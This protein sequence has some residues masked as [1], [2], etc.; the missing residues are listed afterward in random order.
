MSLTAL[1]QALKNATT[2]N[3]VSHAV[4]IYE[5]YALHRIAGRDF[6]Y[7]GF[8]LPHATFRWAGFDEN[9]HCP[10]VLF[11]FFRRDGDC[12][13]CP[14]EAQVLLRGLRHRARDC[15]SRQENITTT[16]LLLASHA[17]VMRKC[18]SSRED[19]CTPTSV[20]QAVEGHDEEY[21][22][23][24]SPTSRGSVVQCLFLNLQK[25]RSSLLAP[26]RFRRAEVLIQPIIYELFDGN[27]FTFGAERLVHEV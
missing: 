8:A 17:S 18:S 25:V 13:A 5:S 27:I 19:L 7:E 23:L 22:G 4:P 11:H 24:L 16:S 20:C 14:G 2:M 21:G 26:N 15:G 6:I 1:R 12:S 3:S 9:P 10:R